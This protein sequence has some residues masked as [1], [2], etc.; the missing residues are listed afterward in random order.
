[1][2]DA[3]LALKWVVEEPYTSEARSLL[4]EWGNHRRK[5]LAPALFLCNTFPGVKAGA[6]RQLEARVRAREQSMQL[7]SLTPSAALPLG[8]PSALR[9]EQHWAKS[10]LHGLNFTQGP[11]PWN[12][13][14]KIQR[15][16]PLRALWLESAAA[17]TSN[18]LDYLLY[19]VNT[20]SAARCARRRSSRPEGQGLR[21]K[22]RLMK[23]ALQAICSSG[24]L[25]VRPTNA[26]DKTAEL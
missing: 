13:L 17:L 19:F 9:P 20:C 15:A 1:V 25:F 24:N 10:S 23:Y 6:F 18:V 7:H 3:S 12:R 4:A 26:Q 21:V 22:V 11:T 2:V 16:K 8:P 5:L 14:F